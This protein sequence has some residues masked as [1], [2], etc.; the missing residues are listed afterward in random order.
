MEP[1][2]NRVRDREAKAVNACANVLAVAICVLLY[3][4]LFVSVGMLAGWTWMCIRAGFAI[5]VR[6]V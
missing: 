5:V 1:V 6:M 2:W 4:L 3:S